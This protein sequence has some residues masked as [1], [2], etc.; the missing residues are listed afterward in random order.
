MDEA[1]NL[2]ERLERIEMLRQSEAGARELLPE[3]RALL[4]E[5]EAWVAVEG[6]PA[7]EARRQLGMLAES[8]ARS[9]GS[10]TEEVVAGNVAL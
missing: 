3:L 5:G 6:S 7:R 4:R 2:L 8:L 1:R 9:P 10:S